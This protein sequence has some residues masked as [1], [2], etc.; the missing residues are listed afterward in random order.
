MRH[1]ARSVVQRTSGS[2]L[3]ATA[4]CWVACCPF[5]NLIAPTSMHM[6]RLH[7]ESA[8]FKLADNRSGIIKLNGVVN[9]A[10]RHRAE[11]NPCA[12]LGGVACVGWG[13]GGGPQQALCR[14]VVSA[15]RALHHALSFLCDFLSMQSSAQHSG[16]R[17]PDSGP[18][19]QEC[20]VAR[21][22]PHHVLCAP[23][24]LPA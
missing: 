4:R 10:E 2:W 6:M 9:G 15:T 17:V 16:T 5:A 13:R 14:A 19:C 3:S 11:L 20:H 12:F 7:I 22:V 21:H 8:V 18:F 24:N 1:P 23:A